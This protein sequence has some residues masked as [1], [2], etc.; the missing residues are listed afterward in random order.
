M[1]LDWSKIDNDK[2]FQRLV[3]HLFALE[4]N[5][6]GFIPSSPYAGADGGWDGRYDGCYPPERKKGKWSIESKWTKHSFQQAKNNLQKRV[7]DALL[8]AQAN[9]VDHLRVATNA[10]LR[11]GQVCDLQQLNEGKVKTLVVWHRQ[12]LEIRI[13]KQPFLRHFFFGHPQFPKFVPSPLYF[14]EVE[15]SLLPGNAKIKAFDPCLAKAKEVIVSPQLHVLLLHA[16][17]GF[18]KSHALRQVSELTCEAGATRQ[19]WLVRDGHR[20][21]NEA[22]QDELS[23][24]RKYLLLIDDA[25][26]RLRQEIQN[27]LAFVRHSGGRVKAVIAFRSAGRT[28]INQLLSDARCDDISAEVRILQWD[29]DD[30]LALLRHAAGRTSVARGEEIVAAF[31]NPFI[32]SWIG[33]TFRGSPGDIGTLKARLVADT[34]MDARSAMAGISGPDTTTLLTH[35]A[36]VVPFA[37]ADAKVLDAIA[38]MCNVN[39]DQVR[40]SL[41]LLVS[42]G[43]LRTVGDRLRFDPDMKGDML[44]AD[45]LEAYT[46][47]QTGRIFD[48][49]LEVAGDHFL[50]NIGAAFR[51]CDSPVVRER[52]SAIVCAWTQK[53]GSTDAPTRARRLGYLENLAD[54]V[55]EDC[56]DMLTEYLQLETVKKRKA[57][58]RRPDGYPRLTTDRYGP[59]ILR[60]TKTPAV[61]RHVL[62]LIADMQPKDMG[63]MYSNYKPTELARNCVSPVTNRVPTIL[64]TLGV[65]AGWLQSSTK[66]RV[67]L[68]TAALTEILGEAHERTTSTSRTVSFGQVALRDTPEVRMIR[69]T[70]MS[71]LAQMLQHQSLEVQLAAVDVAQAHGRAPMG[72]PLE[73]PLPLED[74]IIQERKNLARQLGEQMTAT[75]IW[76]F[77]SAIEDLLLRWW[78]SCARGSAEAK[79]YLLRLQRPAEYLAMRYFISPD[80]VVDD[81]RS[82]SKRAPRVKRWEWYV[83]TVK[84]QFAREPE[85]FQAIGTLA[86][87]YTSPSAI[88]DY[89]VDLEKLIAA[90]NRWAHPPVVSRWVALH[91]NTFKKI[92]SMTGLWRRVP[93]HFRIEIDSAL[94]TVH[95]THVKVVAR[96]VLPDPNKIPLAQVEGFLRM[97]KTSKPRPQRDEWLNELIDK[98]NG[99]VR[100]LAARYVFYIYED[101]Q[102]G[103]AIVRILTRILKRQRKIDHL[104]DPIATTLRRSSAWMTKVSTKAVDRLRGMLLSKLRT[105]EDFDHH[106]DDLL[107]FACRNV[108]EACDLIE[109]RV[110]EHERNSRRNLSAARYVVVPHDG[111]GFPQNMLDDFASFKYFMDWVVHGRWEQYLSGR[112][113]LERV[114]SPL[115]KDQKSMPQLIRNLHRYIDEKVEANEVDDALAACTYLPFTIENIDAMLPVAV[116]AQ[117]SGKIDGVKS[118]FSSYSFPSGGWSSVPGQAPPELVRRKAIFLEIAKRT[119]PGLLASLLRGQAKALDAYMTHSRRE[120]EDILNP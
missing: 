8:K 75:S 64:E 40:E 39:A 45:S 120:D 47:D 30:L 114:V 1:A 115:F 20:E 90:N 48:A 76:R 29:N 62:E 11:V 109:H 22:F 89:L 25:D 16:T 32:I 86:K 43:I 52:L 101:M 38:K 116:A 23:P 65:L 88:V 67:S 72:M 41:E 55:P 46:V 119:G 103:K 81:F 84:R 111:L 63:G 59:A 73:R 61:R 110:R 33:Q 96:D 56:L 94:S 10:E 113:D 107:G 104:L 83:G 37:K 36:A 27:L 92:R 26:R 57:S 118:M 100:A 93:N 50:T 2:V 58:D 5:S 13:E 95:K 102:D 106:A 14:Q 51:Y 60:L 42:G 112:S 54:I 7:K 53:A 21:I 74:K 31:R 105:V 24:D 68:I 4:C 44:L 3:N 35:I 117:E 91:P 80:N 78:A 77:R 15:G 70:A 108:A 34:T 85:D 66:G 71:L 99:Q 87:K 19:I 69:D 49:Y 6:P 9:G 97:L 12:D 28:T 98:G 79:K 82:L 18:G 17:G